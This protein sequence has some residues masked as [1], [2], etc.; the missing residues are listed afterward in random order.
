MLAEPDAHG[1]YDPDGQDTEAIYSLPGSPRHYSPIREA[2]HEEWLAGVLGNLLPGREKVA[3]FTGGGS[4][5][6]KSAVLDL[7]VNEY[8][9]PLAM[10]DADTFKEYIPEYRSMQEID[11]DEAARYVHEESSHLVKRAIVSAVREGLS[12]VFDSTFSNQ[13]FL[14]SLIPKLKATGYRVVIGFADC[15]ADIAWARAQ[16]RAAE[17]GRHVPK[18][19][20]YG[21]NERAI[22]G[23]NTLNQLADV[24]YV[25]STVE[26]DDFLMLAFERDP[27]GVVYVEGHLLNRLHERGHQVGFA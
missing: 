7:F 10:L 22:K 11:S 4:G 3:Y 25:Y 13:G 21:T 1:R 12:F 27:E 6:G 20:V 8:E 9:G 26:P 2:L 14:G 15:P 23:L 5:S 24:V 18:D 19:E 16:S 17:I